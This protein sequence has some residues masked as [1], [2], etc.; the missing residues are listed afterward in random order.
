LST[1]DWIEKDYYKVLGVEKDATADQIKKS[2]R[3]LA[4][5]FHPDANADNASAEAKFKEVGEAY[6]VLSDDKKRAEYD[7]ARS[8][9]GSGGYRFPG[10]GTGG[11]AGAS[12]FNLDDLLGR[13][14]GG[15]GGGMGDVFGGLFNRGGGRQQR[16]AR[17]GA[18][19]E[20]DV[21]LSFDE[22]LQGVTLPLR[23][24]GEGPCDSC[25]GT[26][27][28]LGTVPRMCSSCQGTGSLSR[29][30]GG[31]AFA[32]PCRECRGRG[33]VV[34]DPCPT[35]SGNGRARSSRTVQA[36]V[37]AGVKDGTRIRLK[38]KGS[39]GENGGPSGDLFIT[40]HVTPHE[41][42]GRTGDNLTLTLPVTFEEAALGAEVKVPVLGS[43][44]VTL[45]VPPTTQNGRTFRVKGKGVP[46]K[47]GSRG[48]LLV[49][50]EVAVPAKLTTEAREALEAYRTAMGEQSS[51][52]GLRARAGGSS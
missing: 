44:P 9:F 1:K 35:C 19:A 12:G 8:L 51:R 39:P 4:K 45:K 22:A 10:G 13:M 7:E 28:R 43:A 38:G 30:A 20:S 48:D 42:F 46:R 52:A 16:A 3:K 50:V 25:S 11:G 29:N 5:Q 15:Q 47:D 2:Y 36:R 23:L 31:F 26:G 49:T 34:D 14:N 33:L 37:P 24:S 27:A 21:T 40:V 6:E 18:D 32:E 17:R 41:V